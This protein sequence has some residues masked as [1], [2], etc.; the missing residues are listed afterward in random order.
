MAVTQSHFRFG[1]NELTES[2]HG[3]FAA[4]DVSPRAATIGAGVTFLLR[5][6]CQCDATLLSNADFEFQYRKNGGTYTQITT[7]SAAVKAVTPVCWAD[8]ANTTQRLSGTGTFETTSAGCTATGISGGT[9]FDI[10]ASG[11]GETECALQLVAADLASGD[12]LEFRLTRDGA[13]VMDAYAVTPAI[14]F[15]AAVSFNNH[16]A[17]DA[18]TGM[19]VGERIR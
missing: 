11:N 2:T 10:I 5:F 9:A 4:E 12:L 18:S 8:G 16:L 3:W 6:C 7:S 17:A 1:R 13:I 14:T 19:S 15:G